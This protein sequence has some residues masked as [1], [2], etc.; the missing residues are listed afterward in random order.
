MVN[1]LTNAAKYTDAGGRIWADLTSEDG[2]AAL[3][4]R[5]TGAGI[6]PELLNNI[7]E[8]FAQSARSLDR[9]QGGLGVGL[10]VARRIVELHGGSIEAASAGLGQGSEFV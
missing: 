7:F 4:V 3:R 6:A 10:T 1:L 9:S 8:L 5:D 2:K